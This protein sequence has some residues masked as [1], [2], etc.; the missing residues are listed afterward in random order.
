MKLHFLWA[1]LTA[2][3]LATPVNAEKLVPFEIEGKWGYKTP[4][5]KTVLAARY[6]MAGEFNAHGLAA[7]MEDSGP[8]F[9]DQ[10]GKH[11]FQM[12][13]FDNGPDAFSEGLARFLEKGRM[14]FFNEKGEKVIPALFDFAWPFENGPYTSACVGCRSVKETGGEHSQIKGG[15]WMVIDKKGN[16]VIKADFDG[17][18]SI[19]KTEVRGV[20]KGEVQFFSFHQL[21][22]CTGSIDSCVNK[23]VRLTGRLAPPGEIMQHLTAPDDLRPYNYYIHLKDR[24]IVLYAAEKDIKCTGS[25]TVEGRL[26]EV[27]SREGGKPYSAV[28]MRVLSWSCGK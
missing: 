7:V 22:L 3:A 8:Y 15:K 6:W 1:I 18:P 12:F 14:G 11:L 10:T 9:I 24:M 2:A 4:A 27:T 23:R 17:P 21:P 13:L 20:V 26:F 25:F 16:R 19:A 5:G 28:Q